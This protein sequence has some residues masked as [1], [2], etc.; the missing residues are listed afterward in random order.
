MPKYRQIKFFAPPGEYQVEVVSA[1]ERMSKNRNETIALRLSVGEDT[2]SF[3]E[4]LVFTESS[5]WKVGQFLTAMG[6][7]A[8]DDK[9]IEAADYVGRTA[10]AL[11]G[12]R[13]FRGLRQNYIE[14]WL[15]PE[16]ANAESTQAKSPARSEESKPAAVES[17]ATGGAV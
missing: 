17:S 9:D 13:E 14:R 3:R 10:R 1:K 16:T 2:L 8:A 7:E 4:D 12:V 6:E 15:A 11:V 5:Y